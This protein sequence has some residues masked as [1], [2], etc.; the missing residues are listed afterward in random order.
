[1]HRTTGFSINP[2]LID[3][4]PA[5]I[6]LLDDLLDLSDDEVAELLAEV[7]SKDRGFVFVRRQADAALGDQ[8]SAMKL[9]GVNVDRETRREMPAGD[10]E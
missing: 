8:I 3:N 2:K 7:E 5:T 9:V 1:M 10:T 6:Q 4:G